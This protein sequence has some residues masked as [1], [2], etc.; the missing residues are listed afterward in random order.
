ML[1]F[2][3]DGKI[4]LVTGCNSGIGLA[5]AIEMAQC[6]ADIIGVSKSLS[7][8]GSEIA[9]AVEKAGRKFYAYTA[10]FADRDSIYQFID[11][12]KQHHPRIDILVNN[13]GH[14]LRKPIA[15]HPD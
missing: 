10:D 9:E 12:V 1:N 11:L 3:L 13:A 14:I 6:G 8:T 15:E 5:V 7:A 2:R 4:A